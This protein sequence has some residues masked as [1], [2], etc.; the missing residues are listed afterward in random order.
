MV[1]GEGEG[2]GERKKKKRRR[3]RKRAGRNLEGRFPHV[4]C[5]KGREGEREGA[6]E[7]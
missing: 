5:R 7:G 3:R 2:E 6:R 1:E 4:A